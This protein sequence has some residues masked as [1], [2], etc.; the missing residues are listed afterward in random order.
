MWFPSIGSWGSAK[1]ANGKE[2]P[3]EPG[4]ETCISDTNSHRHEDALYRKLTH[5]LK[6]ATA[7]HAPGLLLFI[8]SARCTESYVIGNMCQNKGQSPCPSK[9]TFGYCCASRIDNDE[10]EC[11]TD[12][13]EHIFAECVRVFR[14][15]RFRRVVTLGFCCCCIRICCS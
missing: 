14:T 2:A 5:C 8:E 9:G 6:G 4:A 10:N 1:A 11:S 7:R 3:G 15:R 12:T 13:K